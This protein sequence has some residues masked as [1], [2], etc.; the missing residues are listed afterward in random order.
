MEER[1]KITIEF[2]KDATEATPDSLPVAHTCENTL[3]F[4]HF[5]YENDADKLMRKLRTAF[6]LCDDCG[7]F[8]MA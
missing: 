5:A 2:N 6:N 4:P 3:K 8:G 1:D 7:A